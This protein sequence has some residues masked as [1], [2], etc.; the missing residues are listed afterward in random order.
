MYAVCG[1]CMVY[2]MCA[3]GV[4]L[5]GVY[6]CV[7]CVCVCACVSNQLHELPHRMVIRF[8]EGTIQ[9][10]KAEATGL[11]SLGTCI[12]SL[13]LCSIYPKKS[14]PSPNLRAGN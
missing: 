2:G 6:V 9:E 13:T 7:V 1:V 10:A 4:C 8:Q 14:K 5:C 3:C 12:S 11:C